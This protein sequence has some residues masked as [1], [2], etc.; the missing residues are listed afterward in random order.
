VERTIDDTYKFAISNI[1][2]IFG[3]AWFPVLIMIAAIGGAAW[4]LLPDLRS[5]DWS[6]TPGI[7]HNQA[8]FAGIGFKFVG[9]IFPIELLFYLLFA[10]I[11]VGMQRKALG[12]IE[13]PVFAYFSLGGAVWRLLGGMI[14]AGI[15]FVIGC[16]LTFGAVSVVYWAGEH[17]ALP[18]IYGLVEFLATIAAICLAFYV[19]VRLFFFIPP[20]VVAEGG[21]GIVRSWELGAGN[22]WRIV[23]IFLATVFGP[24][25]AISMVSQIIVMPFISSAMLQAQHAA[26]V[27]RQ[28]SPQQ[29]WDTMAP[30]LHNFLPIYIVF[31]IVTMP[32]VF[33]LSAAASAF[34]YRNLTRS[35]IPT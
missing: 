18:G 23:V 33:G 7:A 12:L 9:L 22:F 11:Q 14:A 10:M 29:L 34:A 30:A 6:A 3:I 1:L 19:A 4:L 17:Y 15:L 32:I 16:A 8:V 21:F 27:G 20:A 5:I 13:G 25:I 26:A 35:G 28:L 2:S 24:M 31:Q